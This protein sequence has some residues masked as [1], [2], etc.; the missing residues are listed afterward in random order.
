MEIA[1]ADQKFCC[2]FGPVPSRRLGRSLGINM[3]AAKICSYSCVYC[4]AGRN[5]ALSEERRSCL[6]PEEVLRDV[7]NRLADLKADSKTVDY[8]TFVPDGE[9]TLDVHLGQEISL[10]RQFGIP[11]AVITNGSLL[12]RQEV[13]EELARADWVSVKID[14]V[15]DEVWRKINRPCRSLQLERILA[16]IRDFAKEFK[17]D[18]VTETMLVKGVNDSAKGMQKVA[19][20]IQDLHPA[21]AYLS[22]P[23]RPPLE[24]WV[25]APDMDVLNHLYQILAEKVETAEYLFGY[26][27]DDFD[28]TGEITADILRITAVHPLREQAANALLAKAGASQEVIDRLIASGDLVKTMYKEHVF[29][30]RKAKFK[31]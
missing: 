1:M 31:E 6:L 10:L 2:S 15:E 26:E 22:I 16:G 29:Y 9:P 8:L 25:G 27:G 11:V 23:L 17:G 5:T 14:S 21:Q 20:F 30:L 28:S 18:L 4:Q 13:S 3:F 12:W 24:R 7:S 19:E